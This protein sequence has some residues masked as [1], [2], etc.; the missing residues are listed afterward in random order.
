MNLELS[1]TC[2]DNAQLRIDIKRM[3]EK[4]REMIDEYHR[5]SV[6]MKN[7][8]NESRQLT[9]ECSDSYANRYSECYKLDID[10]ILSY[11]FK[12]MTCVQLVSELTSILIHSFSSIMNT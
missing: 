9:S 1:K 8:T 12:Y 3:L 11:S 5:L 2:A 4:R 6:A 10:P 7:A